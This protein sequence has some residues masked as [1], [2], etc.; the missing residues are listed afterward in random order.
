MAASLV[1]GA[2]LLNGLRHIC[3]NLKKKGKRKLNCQQKSCLNFEKVCMK[4]V[5]DVLYLHLTYLYS[6]N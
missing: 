4:H 5:R 3:K 6:N 1:V 2:Q